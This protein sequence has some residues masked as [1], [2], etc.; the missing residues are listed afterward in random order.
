MMF[1]AATSHAPR[2]ASPAPGWAIERSPWS[3][4]DACRAALESWSKASA[5]SRSRLKSA[6][7]HSLASSW[8][9]LVAGVVITRVQGRL[10]VSMSET[11]TGMRSADA[12][13]GSKVQAPL[14]INLHN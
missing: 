3:W 7:P 8:S 14:C 9:M 2:S 1:G 4:M 6:A 10:P 13:D 12:P 5:D 11:L